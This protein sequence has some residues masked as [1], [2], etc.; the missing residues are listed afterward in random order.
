[1]ARV[2]RIISSTPFS[3]GVRGDVPALQ[4]KPVHASNGEYPEKIEAEAERRCRA[5]SGSRLSVFLGSRPSV[6]TGLRYDPCQHA[7]QGQLYRILRRSTSPFFP[8][9]T[10]SYFGN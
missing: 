9:A 6:V 10:V 3:D 8:L 1:M 2:V 4:R 7:N 5:K